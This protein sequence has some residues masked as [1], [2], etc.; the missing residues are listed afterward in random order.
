MAALTVGQR[1]QFMVQNDLPRSLSK[2]AEVLDRIKQS[3]KAKELSYDDI[4]AYLDEVAPWGKQHVFLFKGPAGSIKKTWKNAKWIEERLAKKAPDFAELIDAPV[5]V[6]LPDKMTPVAVEVSSKNVCLKFVQR[7]ELIQHDAEYNK[8]NGKTP[9]GEIIEYRAYVHRVVR[10]HVTFEWDTV[11][12]TAML[13]ITQLPGR[14]RYDRVH[15]EFSQLVS[16]WLTLSQFRVV[17][18]QKAIVKLCRLEKSGKGITRAHGVDIHSLL[19]RSISAKSTTS[20]MSV[21]GE[22]S[23]DAVFDS[24]SK[25]G[26]GHHGNFYWLPKKGNPLAEELR[27]SLVGNKNRVNFTSPSSEA[28]VRHVLSDIRKHC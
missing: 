3:L 6:G 18:L 21:F 19:G 5:Q 24:I 9:A 13:R 8:P 11:N 17:N 14:M 12:N 27:V 22:A 25:N 1:E 26:T 16:P 7:R 23:V 4:V 2:S 10:N 28:I 15:N 20:D